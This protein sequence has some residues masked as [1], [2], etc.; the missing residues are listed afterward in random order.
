MI[1][2]RPPHGWVGSTFS[3]QAL[4]IHRPPGAL[5]ALMTMPAGTSK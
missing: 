3:K 5:P 1:M 4:S 2:S